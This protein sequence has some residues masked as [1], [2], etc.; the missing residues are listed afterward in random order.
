M[1][2]VPGGL[3]DEVPEHEPHVHVGPLVRPVRHAT[4]G[5]E[6][7]RDRPSPCRQAAEPEQ[8]RSR[9]RE[10]PADV[11]LGQPV[12]LPQHRLAMGLQGLHQPRVVVRC[13]V[14]VGHRDSVAGHVG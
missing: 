1:T 14:C 3:G 5:V 6:P 8:V 10:W 9:R 2:R 13:R 11:E 12:E 4:H 7:Q